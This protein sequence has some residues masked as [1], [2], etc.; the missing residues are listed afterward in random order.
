MRKYIIVYKNEEGETEF[1]EDADIK[2]EFPTYQE[3]LN[4]ITNVEPVDVEL[5]IM[6]YEC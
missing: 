5:D 1:W 6:S 4:Y 2:T 3:A